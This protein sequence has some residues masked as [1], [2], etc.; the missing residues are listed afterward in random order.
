[1]LQSYEYY[2]THLKNDLDYKVK[3]NLRRRLNAVL[4]G[5][6]KHKRTLELLGCSL[7]DFKS[8]LESK[9]TEG[10][11]WDNYGINGWHIDHIKPLAHFDLK[12][13]KQHEEATHYTNMQPL[14][15]KDN[16]SKSDRYI[17]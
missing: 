10:M 11:T 4:H 16:C 15:E 2:Q 13:P 1:M 9:F 7:E 5:Q 17:G 6:E 3:A 8:Y 12:D 14:W